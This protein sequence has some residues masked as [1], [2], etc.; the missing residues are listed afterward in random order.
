MNSRA[1]IALAGFLAAAGVT[2][3]VAPD[4]FDS[5]VPEQLPG[6]ARFWTY[7]SGA[8]ELGVAAAVAV[9]RTRRLGGLAAAALFV[10]VFPANVKMAIDWS[11]RSLGEQAVAYGR[12]PL[13]ILLVLWALKVRRDAPRPTATGPAA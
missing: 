5:M 12:L 10:A 3:F 4:F 2:H 9:P 7:A 13:Q 11:D 8:A 1:A 6:T